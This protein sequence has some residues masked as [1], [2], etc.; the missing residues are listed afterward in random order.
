MRK[1]TSVKVGFLPSNRGFFSKELAASMRDQTIAVMRGLGIEVVVPDATQTKVGCVETRQEAELAAEMFRREGVHGILVGAVNFGEEQGVAWCVKKAALN[2][3]IMIYGCQ[4]EERLTMATKRRDAFCGLLS[5][6]EVLRQ[7]GAPYTAAQRPICYPSDPS[8]AADLDWFV[9]ICR[10]VHGLRHAR[11]GQIGARPDAFWTCRYNEKQLQLMGPTVVTLDLSEVFGGANRI[12]DDDPDLAKV[13]ASI[14]GYADTSRIRQMSVTRSAKLELFLRRWG[15]EHAIDAFAIQCWTSIQ[16]NY[17][18]CSCTTMSRFGDEGVPSACEADIMGTLSMHACLLASDSPAG[19]ADW[20][21]LHNDDDELVNVWHCGVFPAAFAKTPVR[22]GVQEIIASS[23]AAKYEDSEGTIEFTARPNPVTLCRVTQDP[24]GAMRAV[25]A[26]GRIEDNPAVTFGCYG[27]CRV[28]GLQRL[29]RDV[30]LRHF[31]H[32]VA[33]T[34]GHVGNVLWEAL[35]NYF[36][37]G[38]HHA[39]QE[40]PGLF[41]PRL[42]FA[43]VRAVTDAPIAPTLSLGAS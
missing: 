18:V 31:P 23:G 35:G 14:R 36:G 12:P 42:P 13:E 21:N 1:A 43:G 15:R 29:Y 6:G 33:I 25:V 3:P 41:T 19:L 16:A 9:R 28:P 8:F 34:Q 30:L 7:I 32:H 27:W 24:T 20:N 11:Y 38:V 2:V 37:I 39:T 10:V 5:I 4:E 22:I 26:E 40:T 17:G